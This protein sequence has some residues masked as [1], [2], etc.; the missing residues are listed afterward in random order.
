[1]LKEWFDVSEMIGVR[2]SGWPETEMGM[3]RLIE[4]EGWRNHGDRCREREGQGGGYEYH[5][6]LLPACVQAKLLAQAGTIK[7][8][9][10][11]AA[12]SEAW[13]NYERLSAKKKQEAKDRLSVVARIDTM[14]RGGMNKTHAVAFVS[15]ETGISSSTLWNWEKLTHG[16]AREDWLAVLAPK[17]P[18]RTVTADCHPAAYEMLKADYLRPEKPGFAACYRRMSEAAVEHGWAPIP[19]AKTLKRRIE[20]EVPAG[21]IVLSREGK[22]AAKQLYPAQTRDRSVFHA[23]EAVN[24]DGHKFDV[25]VRFEDGSIG[26]PLMLAL[27]DLYSGKMLSHR[28]QKSE[29]KDAVRL[30]IGDMVESFGIPDTIYLDN[31]RGFA[32]KWITGRMKNRFRFKVKDEDPAGILTTLG[33]TVHWTTPYSGQSKPI[34]RAFRDLCEEI[35]KHPKCAGAYTGNNPM[36]KPE[37]YGSKAIPIAEFEQHVAE[38]IVRH[39]T[40]EGRRAAVCAGRSFEQAFR[41]SLEDP[42]TIIRTASEAQ[43]RLWLMAAEGVKSRRPSG[44]IHLNGNR[45]WAPVMVEH[46]GSKMIVRFD[47]DNLHDGIFVYRLDGSFVCA[48]ECIEAVGFNDTNAAREHARKRR[49]YLK[50]LREAESIEKSL[51]IQEV[52]DLLPKIEMESEALPEQR[53]VRLAVG[54]DRPVPDGPAWNDEASDSFG[55]AVAAMSNASNRVVPFQSGADS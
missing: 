48:A 24:A 1:M 19:S 6:S 25:F 54:Q 53:V 26:R 43:R 31:G 46:A 17:H 5:V 33:V 35:A 14:Y 40:R 34:E 28:I 50:A 13:A 27:Q 3:S 32:S 39:N 29:N 10:K 16:Y 2:V 11:G 44:E 30:A 7:I 8:K 38:Q 15:Q 23:M 55:R 41:Q 49:A 9:E 47:P 4:R 52:A 21:A 51:D 18:G 12:T 37:N 45:Y 22:D 36:A 42:S 20:R